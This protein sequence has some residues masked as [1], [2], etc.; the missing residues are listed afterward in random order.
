LQIK[1]WRA[2]QGKFKAVLLFLEGLA[3][4]ILL[5]RDCQIWKAAETTQGEER[6]GGETLEQSSR[7]SLRV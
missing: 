1:G 2:E 5:Q 6:G 3:E 7:G 4:E